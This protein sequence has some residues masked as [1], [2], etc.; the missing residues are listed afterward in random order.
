MIPPWTSLECVD[1]GC[2]VLAT[3]AEPKPDA[4]R[5]TVRCDFC[6]GYD[7]GLLDGRQLPLEWHAAGCK[8]V[9]DWWILKPPGYRLSRYP[10]TEARPDECT[11]ADAERAVR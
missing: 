5:D 1:C 6:R 2:E 11:A 9:G 3:R 4:C 8:G 10:W 7:C